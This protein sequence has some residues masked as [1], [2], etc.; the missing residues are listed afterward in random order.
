MRCQ[1]WPITCKCIVEQCLKHAMYVENT[2]QTFQT[3][4]ILV[5]GD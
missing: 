1:S 5:V 4:L 3:K 2:F